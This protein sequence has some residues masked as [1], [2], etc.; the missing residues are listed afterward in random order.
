MSIQTKN[1][2]KTIWMVGCLVT[3]VMLSG[4]SSTPR[5]LQHV[6]AQPIAIQ[7]PVQTQQEQSFASTAG[8]LEVGAA[9][10]IQATPIGMAQATVRSSYMNALGEKCKKIHLKSKS[11][12]ANC[13]VCLGKDGVWRYVPSVQ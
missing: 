7:D 12:E 3:S 5:G 10:I 13:G 9:G 4:C 6:P 2:K 11:T 1:I 8:N